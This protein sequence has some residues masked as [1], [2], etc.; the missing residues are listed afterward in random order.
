MFLELSH[1]FTYETHTDNDGIPHH[2][3]QTIPDSPLRSSSTNGSPIIRTHTSFGIKMPTIGTNHQ[4]HHQD[5]NH[6]RTPSN[7]ANT[8][9]VQPILPNIDAVLRERSLVIA[10]ENMPHIDAMDR[11]HQVLKNFYVSNDKK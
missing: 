2:R 7:R 8:I 9:H 3:L 10:N 4:H 5:S 1:R 6:R 11:V